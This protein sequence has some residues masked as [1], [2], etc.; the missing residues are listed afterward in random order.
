MTKI[1]YKFLNYK[2]C[3]S[4]KKLM[5]KSTEIP[6][7]PKTLAT[8]LFLLRNAARAVSKE[9]ILD[10][11]WPASE[12]QD[13]AVFQ[14]ISELRSI[15]KGLDCIETVRGTGYRWTIPLDPIDVATDSRMP[16]WG[17]AAATILM[18]VVGSV[19]WWQIQGRTPSFSVMVSSAK[20]LGSPI[21]HSS[22][23]SSTIDK[24]LIQQLRRM[25]LDAQLSTNSPHNANQFEVE[26]ESLPVD[27]GV[28]LR[29]RLR[30]HSTI[31]VG[32]LGSTNPLGVVRDLA[33]ELHDSISVMS[34]DKTGGISISALFTR[35]KE[36]MDKGDFSLAS[37]YL[38]AAL[39]ES[40]N[41]KSL[42]RAL[43]Y[44]YHK[45]RRVDDALAIATKMYALA[46]EQG[47]QTDLML[48]AI[49]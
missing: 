38:Q 47:E 49:M 2:I 3:A 17:F 5:R 34:V 26:I 44:S 37:A 27:K 30:G 16:R 45:L 48:S 9:E 18:L 43:A 36:Q 29:Y 25:G 6:V 19:V 32:E 11:I 13:Q 24:M 46:N 40:P 22:E 20:P 21:V 28:F 35:A 41:Q 23:T 31:I 42:Q 10:A 1:S 33:I 39:A 4:E 7:R 12:V 14:S 8:L 15:F